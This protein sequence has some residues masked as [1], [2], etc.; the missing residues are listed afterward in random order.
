MIRHPALH[1]A[2]G[3][4]EHGGS[5]RRQCALSVFTGALLVKRA[6]YRDIGFHVGELEACVLELADLLA[7]CLALLHILCSDVERALRGGH[8]LRGNTESLS[9]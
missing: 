2:A 6:V 9:R 5:V 4:L 1:F 8:R 7:K 3:Q